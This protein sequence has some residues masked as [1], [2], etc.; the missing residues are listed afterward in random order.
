MAARAA[1]VSQD[2]KEPGLD[3][4]RPGLSSTVTVRLDS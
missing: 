1:F 2:A 3:R 4:L